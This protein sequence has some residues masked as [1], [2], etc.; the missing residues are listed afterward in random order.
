MTEVTI[1]CSIYVAK[2][3]HARLRKTQEWYTGI[4]ESAGMDFEL[5]LV[6]DHSDMEI[7][8][9][10]NVL[11]PKG[12]CKNITWAKPAEKRQ[13]KAKNL[14]RLIRAATTPFIAVVD[15][16]V[17]LPATW[18][19]G[20]TLIS[21]LGAK[22]EGRLLGTSTKGVTS[23]WTIGLCGV[24]V[25]EA[26]SF[27]QRHVI[28]GVPIMIPN[29]LGGACLVWRKDVLGEVGYF[30]EGFGLYGSE[31]NEF[32]LRLGANNLLVTA[33]DGRGHHIV[34]SD[35]DPEYIKWK[36][37]AHKESDIAVASTIHAHYKKAGY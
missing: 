14:N 11:L 3:D 1:V 6:D 35:D 27:R 19:V 22:P 2:G 29:L 30:D 7:E 4:T 15:N 32:L 16:D 5:S 31:D 17:I 18:L 24:A 8:A 23:T 12:F 21:G 9:L 10:K 37:A 28:K 34:H 36:L 26:V 20:C 13:G 25:E 33:I